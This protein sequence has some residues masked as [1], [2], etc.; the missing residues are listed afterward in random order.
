MLDGMRRLPAARYPS[1]DFVSHNRCRGEIISRELRGRRSDGIK[2]RRQFPVGVYITDFLS[3][4]AMLMVELD[5]GQH[6][7]SMCARFVCRLNARGFRLLRFWND[8]VM[9][10]MN[11]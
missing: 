2:F 10:E 8:E 3:A 4:E 6:S 7:Q 9:R 11:A 1:S 5:G